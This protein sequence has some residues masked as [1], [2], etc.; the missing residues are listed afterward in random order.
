MCNWIGRAPSVR[1][2]RSLSC[3]S[4]GRYHLRG[5]LACPSLVR[6]RKR[7]RPRGRDRGA[8]HPCRASRLDLGAKV[9]R[10]ISMAWETPVITEI[11][12]GLEVTSYSSG[13]DEALL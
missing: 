10:R 2:Y 11:A 7:R 6:T 4:A 9:S 13:E 12:V 8:R 1:G 3:D 5:S